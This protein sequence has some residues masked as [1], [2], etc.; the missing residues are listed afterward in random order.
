[1]TKQLAWMNT[2]QHAHVLIQVLM[3]TLQVCPLLPGA[4]PANLGNEIL[5]QGRVAY[6]PA[7]QILSMCKALT[8]QAGALHQYTAQ[9]AAGWM[10]CRLSRSDLDV[11]AVANSQCQCA[12]FVS[13][14]D[15]ASP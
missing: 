11:Q 13:C 12:L 3:P 8:L 2:Y 6:A 10:C 14:V 5:L 9:A 15:D 7:L 1:M 4:A